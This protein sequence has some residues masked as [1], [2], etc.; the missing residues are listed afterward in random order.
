VQTAVDAFDRIDVVV[1]AARSA[2]PTVED[3]SVDS[4]RVP[5]ETNLFG[6]VYLIQAAFP[7]LRQRGS[8]H[9]IQISPAG[10]RVNLGGFS[11]H[12]ISKQAVERFTVE[13]ARD[14]APL[15]IKVTTVET[16]GTR[17]TRLEPDAPVISEPFNENVIAPPQRARAHDRQ[18]SN[19]PGEIARLILRIAEMAEPPLR[20]LV[21]SEATHYLTDASQSLGEL[22]AKWRN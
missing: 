8:G 10:S 19:D 3:F 20:L 18:G 9:I 1:N 7:I 12:Q 11:A 16:G 13:L 15:G 2:D 22:E 6:F 21:G 14:L 17:N 5:M 4:F